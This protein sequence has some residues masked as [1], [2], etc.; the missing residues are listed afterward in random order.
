MPV[1]WREWGDPEFC[2]SA[3]ETAIL[4]VLEQNDDPALRA[5]LSDHPYLYLRLDGTFGLLDDARWPT[6]KRQVLALVEVR[7]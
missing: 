4:R 5:D 1:R 6:P 2:V 3:I 7:P